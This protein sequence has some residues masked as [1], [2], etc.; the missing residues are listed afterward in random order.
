[1]VLKITQK[2]YTYKDYVIK[3]KKKKYKIKK[4]EFD[5]LIHH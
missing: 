3:N 4:K 2:C 5:H 1:M